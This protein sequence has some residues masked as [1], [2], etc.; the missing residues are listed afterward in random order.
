MIWSGQR[1]IERRISVH[2]TP[3]GIT[4]EKLI[5]SHMI[6]LGSVYAAYGEVFDLNRLQMN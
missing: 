5:E 2:F 3:P 6:H 1:S 4:V